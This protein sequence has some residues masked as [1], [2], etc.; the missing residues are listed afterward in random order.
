MYRLFLNAYRA[1]PAADV[2]HV[3]LGRFDPGLGLLVFMLQTVHE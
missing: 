3:L 2:T 1:M